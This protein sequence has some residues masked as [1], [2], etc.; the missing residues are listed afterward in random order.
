MKLLRP[1]KGIIF[2]MIHFGV[3]YL[4]SS[5]ELGYLKEVFLKVLLQEEL[6]LKT[7]ISFFNVSQHNLMLVRDH[8]SW[9]HI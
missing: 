2:K 9:A 1:L 8:Q 6:S 5:L 7:E 3:L 4:N